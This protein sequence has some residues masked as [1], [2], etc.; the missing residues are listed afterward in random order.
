MS[1]ARF[2]GYAWYIEK[3]KGYNQK[4]KTCSDCIHFCKDDNSCS[5]NNIHVAN[6]TRYCISYENY[7]I[8]EK[9]A[10]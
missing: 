9:I 10:I 5:K 7:F 8:D 1:N 3:A 6:N 2:T 4:R